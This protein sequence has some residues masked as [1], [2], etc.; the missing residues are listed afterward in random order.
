MAR[1][2]LYV[3]HVLYP[4]VTTVTV[5]HIVPT[6]TLDSIVATVNLGYIIVS[7]HCYRRR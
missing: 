5:D 2:C 7:Y 6:I 4:A 1:P 3:C